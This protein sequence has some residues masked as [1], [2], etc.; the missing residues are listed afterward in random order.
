[1]TDQP[2]I[3]WFPGHMAKTR[4]LIRDSMSLVDGVVEILDARIP[5]SSRNP[6]LDALCGAKPRLLLLNKY[7]LA[8]EAATAD[9]VEYYRSHGRAALATDCKSGRGLQT[10]VPAVRTLLSDKLQRYAA[11]GMAGRPIRLMVAGIPNSG[12][13]TFINRMAGG[14]RARA[15]NRPGVTKSKQWIVLGCGIELLDTPGILWPKFED[16]AVGEKLALVGSIRDEVLDTELLASRLLE[17][18]AADYPAALT[19]RFKL[20]GEWPTEGYELLELVARRRGC[21]VSGGEPD[22]ER[23]ASLVLEEYRSGRLGR[24]SL[25]RPVKA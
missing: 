8:D 25:E 14:K 13:S 12:K 18:L 19:G 22:T 11:G 9:W 1:M 16:P 5:E 21:L 10:F 17:I 15:E 4:R 3:Q 7:D 6:E 20:E 23:A 24:I 2:A